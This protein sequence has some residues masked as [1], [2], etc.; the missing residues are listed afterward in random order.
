MTRVYSS[1]NYQSQNDATIVDGAL[2]G[3]IATV[4]MTI[5]MLVLQ[6]LLPGEE[7]EPLPPEQ[8][9]TSVQKRTGAEKP[10]NEPQR[11]VMSLVAHFG[12]GAAAGA[13]FTSLANILPVPTMV[14]GLVYGLL[15]WAG[16]YLGWLPAAKIL[17]SATKESPWRNLLM[18]VA[19][20]VWGAALVLGIRRLR[21]SRGLSN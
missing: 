11:D 6:Q 1:S 2:A 12:F 14:S 18:I 17:P 7:D 15:V 21:A 19:H 10:E 13:V 3:L 4:P 8:I 20:L 5:V 9:T 16:S